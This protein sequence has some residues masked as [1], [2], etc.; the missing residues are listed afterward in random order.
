MTEQELVDLL[1]I[2]RDWSPELRAQFVEGIDQLHGV[3]LFG[4]ERPDIAQMIG[5]ILMANDGVDTRIITKA[6]CIERGIAF[7]FEPDLIEALASVP[8]EPGTIAVL[9]LGGGHELIF[10]LPCVMIKMPK[11]RSQGN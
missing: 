5:V 4:R 7:G 6:N 8:V 1:P 9:C 2:L 3:A 11:A 10:N